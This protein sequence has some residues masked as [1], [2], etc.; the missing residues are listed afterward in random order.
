MLDLEFDLYLVLD[1]NLYD[2]FKC[3][4]FLYYYNIYYTHHIL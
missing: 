2:L 3:K 1:V 4:Y